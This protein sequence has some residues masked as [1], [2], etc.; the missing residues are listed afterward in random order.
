MFVGLGFEKH[1]GEAD[2]AGAGGFEFGGNFG[3]EFAFDA[4]SG[5]GG[6]A[7]GLGFGEKAHLL[8]EALFVDGNADDVAAGAPWENVPAE[9]FGWAVGLD[10]DVLFVD[11]MGSAVKGATNEVFKAVANFGKEIEDV[12]AVDVVP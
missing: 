4:G 12:A 1:V 5:F 10:V 2:D 8:G 6:F 11:E 3:E 9:K 7:R